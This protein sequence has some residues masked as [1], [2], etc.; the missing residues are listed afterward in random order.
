MGFCTKCG[1]KL[2]EDAEFCPY[3][4]FPI[5]KPEPLQQSTAPTSSSVVER[6]IRA[7]KLDVHLYEEV[8]KDETAT[9]QALLVVILASIS[10]GI[11]SAVSIAMLG[12]EPSLILASLI[13]GLI[14]S[15]FGWLVWSFITYIIGTKV[16]GG[17]ATYGELLRTIGFSDAPGLLLVFSFIPLLG[18]VISFLIGIWGLVAMAIAVRQALDFSTTN[19]ILT[20]IVGFIAY[21][22]FE[23]ILFFI[24]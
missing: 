15:L 13:S 10:S 6:M 20:C 17:I 8:E 24:I 19:A 7:A 16:F 4:G 5:E 21:I 2:P 1:S 23:F 14:L 3:C 22:V 18:G 11:G 9:L 12:G